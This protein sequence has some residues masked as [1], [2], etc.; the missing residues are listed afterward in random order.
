[1]RGTLM[2]FGCFWGTFS[3]S[4]RQNRSTRRPSPPAS[5]HPSAKLRSSGS[6]SGR[7]LSPTPASRPPRAATT[8]RGLA[9]RHFKRST[10]RRSALLPLRKV[11]LGHKHD[12]LQDRRLMT[13]DSTSMTRC[14]ASISEQ[15]THARATLPERPRAPIR[16][17]HSSLPI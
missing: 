11:G 12:S 5:R 8:S 14:G 15:K 17:G 1:M 7:R 16:L 6:H 9:G 10:Q 13:D 2:D 3:P 4:C